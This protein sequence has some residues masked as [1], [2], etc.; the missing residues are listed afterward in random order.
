LFN[1]G[2]TGLRLWRTVELLRIIDEELRTAGATGKPRT[3]AIHGNRFLAHQ[4]LRR[5][6]LDRLDDPVLSMDQFRLDARNLVPVLLGKTCKAIES[7]YSNAY[8]Q[9]LFKNV[10][11]CKEMD[12]WMAEGIPAQLSSV[13]ITLE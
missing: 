7:L 11:K 8:V 6:K 5:L 13:V 12:L 10:S 1:S 3:V 2:L 4:V 9:A